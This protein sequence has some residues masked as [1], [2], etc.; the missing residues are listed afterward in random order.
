MIWVAI[1]SSEMKIIFL[2][3]WGLCQFVQPSL[4]VSSDLATE[5]YVATISHLP[6]IWRSDIILSWQHSFFGTFDQQTSD[7]RQLFSS[8]QVIFLRKSRRDRAYFLP[9]GFLFY[10]VSCPNYFGEGLQ[11]LGWAMMTW[12]LAG[13]VWWLYTE[14]IFIPR[15]GHNHRWYQSQFLNYPSHRKALIPLIY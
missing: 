4:S 15:S 1:G 10:L 3:Q 13:L 5:V 2:E 9:R 7:V 14:S 8:L 11:W 6:L 12:S